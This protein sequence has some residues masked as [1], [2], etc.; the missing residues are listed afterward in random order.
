MV[1]RMNGGGSKRFCFDEALEYAKEVATECFENF[2]FSIQTVEI[3]QILLDKVESHIK[4]N[5]RQIANFIPQFNYIDKQENIKNIVYQIASKFEISQLLHISDESIPFIDN[6]FYVNG[7]SNYGQ[8]NVNA[9]KIQHCL[10]YPLRLNNFKIIDSITEDFKIQA[11]LS[12]E[13]CKFLGKINLYKNESIEYTIEMKNCIFYKEVTMSNKTFKG[14]VYFNNSIFADYTD[15]HESKFSQTACFYGVTFKELP[16]FSA[17]YFKE[18]KNVNVINVDIS[19]FNF[20]KVEDYIDNNFNSEQCRADIRQNETQQGKIEQRYRLKCAKDI[21]DSF[22]TIKDV[23]VEQNNT[24]EAQEWHKLE[25]YAKE[26][27]IE[28][29]LKNVAKQTK[30]GNNVK[31]ELESITFNKTKL[32]I[33]FKNIWKVCMLF[34]KSIC[35]IVLFFGV[36]WTIIKAIFNG[37]KKLCKWLLKLL[38]YLLFSDSLN[39]IKIFIG[40][41]FIKL[42][43]SFNNMINMT[44]W[45]DVILLHIYR[46]TSDHHTN[47]LRILNWTICMIAVYSLFNFIFIKSEGL[48]QY[49]YIAL[50]IANFAI[51]VVAI[52]LWLWLDNERDNFSQHSSTNIFMIFLPLLFIMGITMFIAHQIFFFMLYLISVIICYYLFICRLNIVIFSLRFFVYMVFVFVLFLKPQLI[53]PFIGI[54]SY[55]KLIE[56]KLEA[57]LNKLDSKTIIALAKISQKQF[58]PQ[59]NDNNISLAESNVAKEI[60]IA[61]KAEL[62]NIISFLFDDNKKID[63]FKEILLILKYNPAK[64]PNAIKNIDDKNNNSAMFYDVRKLSNSDF[65][66]TNDSINYNLD[67]DFSFISIKPSCEDYQIFKLKENQIKLKNILSLIN[68]ES[69]LHLREIKQAIDYDNIINGAI[70]S[71]SIIYSIILLLCIFSLQ[72]TARKNSIIPS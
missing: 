37:V 27:E 5:E 21:K 17:C 23:L 9:T 40:N 72:K 56:S 34:V 20:K 43:H 36:L 2:Y 70:K 26:K 3:K 24:L 18:P 32:V 1:Y 4:G 58:T 28:F 50:I 19:N 53:N 67:R 22:R 69:E 51:F 15:F 59:Y 13:N 54:F 42:N 65:V 10:K 48:V 25:L 33:F 14:N 68:L 52:I 46:N 47:L 12:F 39:N 62:D 16:N 30:L 7:V 66:R 41:T 57:K 55:D 49:S 6:K 8:L 71:T 64:L 35:C 45:I 60:I 29:D 61:N 63:G 44:A 38:Y 31:N 11:D